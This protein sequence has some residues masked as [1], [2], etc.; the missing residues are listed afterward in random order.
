[1]I[2]TDLRQ[3]PNLSE[4]V[5]TLDSVA[6]PE[7][8][9][10]GEVWRCCWDT[11]FDAFAAFQIAVTDDSGHVIGVGHSIPIT[12]DGTVEGLPAGWDATFQ[13]AVD[14]HEHAI[15]PNA[16][17]G[18]SVVVPPEAQGQGISVRILQA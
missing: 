6:W 14:N 13:L 17:A 16:L 11:L 12:W 18:I 10:H 7:F 15:T 1:M 2:V 3:Q 5:Q 8:M 4:Q 9:Y